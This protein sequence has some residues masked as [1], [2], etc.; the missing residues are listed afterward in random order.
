[1]GRHRDLA[2]AF[3]GSVP[4]GHATL[5]VLDGMLALMVAGRL[6]RQVAAYG[7]D[8]LPMYIYASAYEGSLFVQRM[9]DEPDYFEKLGRYMRSL[10]P[11]RYPTATGMVE[12]LLAHDDE[13]DRRF[14]FGLD[15]IVRG[16][17][18]MA[19]RR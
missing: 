19:S 8:L 13:T 4:T 5:K 2:R 6:P 14:E 15:V 7:A 3:L 10:P 18:A 17:A 9:Q 1:M 11:E 12:E 16:L